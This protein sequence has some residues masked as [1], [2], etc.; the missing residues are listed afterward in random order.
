MT[1]VARSNDCEAVSWKRTGDRPEA[2]L[3]A[4]VGNAGA[5]GAVPAPVAAPAAV[6]RRCS[7]RDRPG[8]KSSA[9]PNG[10]SGVRWAPRAQAPA[11]QL[12]PSRCLHAL[13]ETPA[14]VGTRSRIPRAA[15]EAPPGRE[16]ATP[17]RRAVHRLPPAVRGRYA[18]VPEL[19]RNAAGSGAAGGSR[20]DRGRQ[21]PALPATSCGTGA[22][23][24]RGVPRQG[25][26]G[27][28]GAAATEAGQDPDAG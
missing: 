22:D 17:C 16:T 19:S 10:L 13:L 28:P 24:L 7:T 15:A 26:S 4:R 14:A 5:G 11:R 27:Q 12:P 6:R 1:T 23:A 9:S 3:Q 21:L 20:A 18:P 25:A 8:G 2:P